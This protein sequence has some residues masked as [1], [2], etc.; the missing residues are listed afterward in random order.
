LN[1]TTAIFDAD[2]LGDRKILTLAVFNQ[3]G[4]V[5]PDG[6]LMPLVFRSLWAKWELRPMAI[7]DV[8]R[9]PSE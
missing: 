5:F 1:G 3:D 9:I 2:L 6:Y 8:H 7:D 4:A